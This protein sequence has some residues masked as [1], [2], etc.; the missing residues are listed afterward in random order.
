[1]PNPIVHSAYTSRDACTYQFLSIGKYA[2]SAD[3]AAVA[4]SEAGNARNQILLV[5]QGPVQL[6]EIL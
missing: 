2:P 1:M 6:M 3:A 4:A 5:M